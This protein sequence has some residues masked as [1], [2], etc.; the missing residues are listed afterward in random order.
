MA[1]G[2]GGSGG[3]SGGSGGGVAAGAGKVFNFAG[4]VLGGYASMEAH[5]F[6]AEM[7][8]A[9]AGLVR[10]QALNEVARIRRTAKKDLGDMRA[11]YGANGVTASGSVL[12]AMADAATQ[13]ELDAQLANWQGE[14]A[15]VGYIN[16]ARMEKAAGRSAMIGAGLEGLGGLLG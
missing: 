10:A 4:T 7:A 9:N 2:G 16:Q 8:E 14:V 1:E 6:N 11:T 13:Y 3:A 15:A 12:D 5:K